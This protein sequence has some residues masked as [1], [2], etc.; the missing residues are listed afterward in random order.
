MKAKVDEMTRK[1]VHRIL[2]AIQ[3]D[4]NNFR[5]SG[6]DR[7]YIAANTWFGPHEEEETFYDKLKFKGSWSNKYDK[8][9]HDVYEKIKLLDEPTHSYRY[10]TYAE[11]SFNK[12]C[13]SMERNGF[14]TIEY[15]QRLS[16]PMEQ[17]IVQTNKLKT[18]R[19]TEARI[20]D[21][22]MKLNNNPKFKKLIDKAEHALSINDEDINAVQL[23]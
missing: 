14:S 21:R 12:Y 6:M 13:E 11:E 23:T 9:L 8:K 19:K 7:S 20:I 15:R 17:E 18:N 5:G 22:V 1:D 2:N 10:R 4:P 16:I 3:M